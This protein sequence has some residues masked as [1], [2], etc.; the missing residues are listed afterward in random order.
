MCGYKEKRTKMSAVESLHKYLNDNNR[1]AFWQDRLHGFNR[2]IEVVSESYKH[3][4]DLHRKRWTL[5]QN[6]TE[7]HIRDIQRFGNGQHR[8]LVKTYN[9]SATVVY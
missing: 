5:L 2:R 9:D 1:M 3:Q 6:N 4:D 7:R 8:A